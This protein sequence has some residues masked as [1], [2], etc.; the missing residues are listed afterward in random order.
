MVIR[1][2]C[3]GNGV[4]LVESGNTLL[5]MYFPEAVENAFVLRIM[6]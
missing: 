3:K 5:K 1:Y 4:T 2:L 6:E